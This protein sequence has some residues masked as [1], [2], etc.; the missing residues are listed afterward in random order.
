MTIYYWIYLT[1]KLWFEALEVITIP[2]FCNIFLQAYYDTQSE[3]KF[4]FDPCTLS[5][6]VL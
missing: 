5:N 1:T 2:E 3:S 4:A 6:F